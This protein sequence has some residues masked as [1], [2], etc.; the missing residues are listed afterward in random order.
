MTLK[1]RVPLCWTLFIMLILE[2]EAITAFPVFD[3]IVSIVLSLIVWMTGAVYVI[4]KLRKQNGNYSYYEDHSFTNVDFLT[5]FFTVTGGIAVAAGNYLYGGLIPLFA[6]EYLSGHLLYTIRNLLYYPT[7]VLLMLE[8]LI[9]SQKA[10]EILT[11]K[12]NIPWGALVLFILWGLPHIIWHGFPDGVVAALR[13]FIYAIPFYAAKK[14][15]KTSYIS[16]LILW[17]M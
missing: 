17:L 16:M 3:L 7:E 15:I 9:T 8:L 13:A 14:N 1:A 11:N 10:G 6:R 12:V 5:L 4:I 2:F